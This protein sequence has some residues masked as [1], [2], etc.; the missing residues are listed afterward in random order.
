MFE[1]QTEDTGQLKRITA[2]GAGGIILGLVLVV[3]NL[4]V[5][6]AA[7]PGYSAGNAVFG[8]FGLFVMTVAAH[9]TY[10]AAVELD[11]S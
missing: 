3:L 7:G 5:P 8:L 4:V 10:H 1:I 11:E 2:A 9:P 6:L